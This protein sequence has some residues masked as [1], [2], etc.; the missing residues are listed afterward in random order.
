MAKFNF[1]NT[2]P[3][4]QPVSPYFTSDPVPASSGAVAVMDDI[5]CTLQR[6]DLNET[7]HYFFNPYYYT[8]EGPYALGPKE[9]A[10]VCFDRGTQTDAWNGYKAS[11]KKQTIFFV[12]QNVSPTNRLNIPMGSRLLDILTMSD[13]KSC[14]IPVTHRF[15][16]CSGPTVE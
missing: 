9:C 7:S 2:G 13:I 15:S 8:S 11:L 3:G 5:L 12:L 6:L 10:T 4:N 16:F 14:V 1:N